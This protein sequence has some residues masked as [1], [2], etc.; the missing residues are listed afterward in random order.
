MSGKRAQRR[1]CPV[2]HKNVATYANGELWLHYRPGWGL[3]S[4]PGG[5]WCDGSSSPW[6]RKE[7][8]R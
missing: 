5:Q 1:E 4:D 7:D 6:K 2:C 8:V 3:W